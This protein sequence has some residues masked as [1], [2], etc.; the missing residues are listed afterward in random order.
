[1]KRYFAVLAE[2]G[3]YLI[4]WMRTAVSHLS[5]GNACRC[6]DPGHTSPCYQ[7]GCADCLLLGGS[8]HVKALMRQPWCQSWQNTSPSSQLICSLGRGPNELIRNWTWPVGQKHDT[9]FY[10]RKMCV[11][12][13]RELELLEMSLWHPKLGWH[14]FAT[15]L[16]LCGDSCTV[17]SRGLVFLR[18][19]WD[20]GIAELRDSSSKN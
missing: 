17:E 19:V 3:P 2:D 12:P 11:H 1:M 16:H 20:S 7:S 9:F 18:D 13:V 10:R 14:C 6:M 4:V 15:S 5:D 8:A